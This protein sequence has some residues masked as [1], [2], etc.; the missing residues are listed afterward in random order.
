ML[1]AKRNLQVNRKILILPIILL[2]LALTACGGS[3]NDSNV[4]PPQI[5]VVDTD[6]D[7]IADASDEFP[8]D[9]SLAFKVSG[10]VTG[11]NDSVTVHLDSQNTAFNSDG[12]FEFFVANKLA[13]RG[14]V[15]FCAFKAKGKT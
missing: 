10:T 4:I 6:N 9:A 12:S 11:L 2:S 7:G 3:D 1:T 14:Q 5:V 15:L 13:A 8:T